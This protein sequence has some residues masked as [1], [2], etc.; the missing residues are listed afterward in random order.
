MIGGRLGDDLIEHLAQRR[1]DAGGDREA[2]GELRL[3]TGAL[4]EHDRPSR[5]GTGDVGTVVL[6][7]ER[8]GEVHAGSGPGGRGDMSVAHED[9]VGGDLNTG[10]APGQ[11]RAERPMGRCGSAVEQARR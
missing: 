1:G 8:E 4:K 3:A 9:S 10:M 5:H 6:L 2:L 7:D 11:V